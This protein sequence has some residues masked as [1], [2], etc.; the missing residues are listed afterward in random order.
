MTAQ[1]RF[2]VMV[3]LDALCVMVAIAALVA[4]LSYHLAYGLPAF[5][6]AML[7]GF[8]AQLWF[9]AGLAKDGRL[10]KGV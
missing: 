3:G 10:E 2:M 4:G 6:A 1:Q 5:A 9:I 7:V 8:G